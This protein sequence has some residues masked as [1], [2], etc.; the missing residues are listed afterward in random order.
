ML[1]TY[2]L[3]FVAAGAYLAPV[4]EKPCES[5]SGNCYQLNIESTNMEDLRKELE[6]KFTDILNENMKDELMITTELVLNDGSKIKQPPL[7]TSPGTTVKLDS[8][9]TFQQDFT[10]TGADI[11]NEIPSDHDAATTMTPVDTS[12]WHSKPTTTKTQTTLATTVKLGT[13]SE[14]STDLETTTKITCKTAPDL[15]TDCS[16]A[17]HEK[18]RVRNT[19]GGVFDI[20]MKSEDRPIEVYC[21]LK[22]DGGGWTVFQRRM[23][24]STKF[25][26]TWK[27]YKT[28]FGDADRDMWL[29]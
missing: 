12:D 11:E 22:T 4:P 27:E 29:G 13:T 5:C 9:S 20:C 3:P 21:D 24:G 19:T 8:T 7:T 26:R 14:E 16:N 2:L 18:A 17:F 1:F 25:D 6:E 28:G 23:D 15:P 10:T